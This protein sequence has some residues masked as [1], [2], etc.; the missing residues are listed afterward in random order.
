MKSKTYDIK[1]NIE[2]D[3]KEI[4]RIIRIN[5]PLMN[6]N[7]QMIQEV[8]DCILVTLMG[9]WRKDNEQIF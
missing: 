9:I 7:E 8:A 1:I 5:L 6:K 4:A 2:K 3:R